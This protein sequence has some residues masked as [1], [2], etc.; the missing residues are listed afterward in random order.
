[1]RVVLVTGSGQGIG[2][3]S[4][5]ALARQGYAV[6]A[7][8]LAR[9]EGATAQAVIDEIRA[10][11]GE[12]FV[13][14]GSVAEPAGAVAAVEAALGAYGRLDALVAG[15]GTSPTSPFAETTVAE[16]DEQLAV[17]VRGVF[18]L[19]R[20]AVAH[21]RERRYGRIVLMGSGVGMYG[22]PGKSAYGTAKAALVGLCK[23]VALETAGDGVTVN[24]VL[25]VAPKWGR[26]P[27]A[28]VLPE[29]LGPR[30]TRLGP[31]WVAPLVGYLAGEAC[32][33]TGGIYSALAGRYA[34]VFTAAAPGWE[35]PGAEPP[36]PGELGAMLDRICDERGY[37]E[38]RWVQDEYEEL[39]RR[40]WP[41]VR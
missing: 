32:T 4:A 36:T 29:L 14:A 3:A 1:V 28:S 17:H 9:P 18:A 25:P 5:L 33:S 16:L 30:A 41:P 8:S 21:M 12:G 7:N 26:T 34:R 11:G 10:A 38:P 19:V 15:A 23:V 2:R 24:V 6:V 20:H 27:G 13:Y 35:A 22:R 31:E 37:V 40:P 39:G